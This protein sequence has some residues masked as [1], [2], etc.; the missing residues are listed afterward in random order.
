MTRV[1]VA[2]AVLAIFGCGGVGGDPGPGLQQAPLVLAAGMVPI[3]PAA[4]DDVS[5]GVDLARLGLG[6]P[7]VIYELTTPAN[8]P[9]VFDLLSRNEGNQGAVRV[10]VAHAR[11]GAGTPQGG[12]ETLA[13]VGVVPSG[14]GAGGTGEWYDAAGDGFAR[15][16]ISGAIDRDQILAVR[17]E[18]EAGDTTALVWIR[19]GP[20]SPINTAFT[21]GRNYAGVLEERTIY[22][23][24]SY[25]F[26]LPAIAV[27]GDRTTVVA[28]DGDQADPFRFERYEMRLQVDHDTGDVTGGAS[29]EPSPDTGYWRDHEIAALF[30]VLAVVTAGTDEVTLKL[31]FDRG[32][33]FAQTEEFVAGSSLYSARLVQI[34]MAADYTLGLVFWRPDVEGTSELIFVEGRP[35]AFDGGGSPTGFVFDAPRTLVRAASDIMPVIMGMDYSDGGDLVIG[36]GWSRVAW[37]PETRVSTIRTEFHA[38]VRMFG[39]TGFFDSLVEEDVTIARDPSV[40]LIRGATD[41]DDRDRLRIFYAYEGRNGVRH[42]TSDDGGRSWSPPV[43]VG[44]R[45]SY[46]PMIFAR[47]GDGRD[48]RVDILYLTWGEFGTELHLRHFEAYQRLAPQTFRLTESRMVEGD[49][50]VGGGG[51][52]GT[53]RPPRIAQAGGAFPPGGFKVTQISWFGYDATRDG[54]DIVVVFNEQT[55]SPY[56]VIFA[57]GD[58]GAV[59]AAGSA[60]LPTA[61]DGFVPAE[62]PPLAPGLTEP[63]R[64]PNPDHSNQLRVIRLE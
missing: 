31:S 53:D 33:T 58:F 22:S 26:G 20:V 19:V 54:D 55:T 28:Y 39:E 35:A 4:T 50:D 11:D 43:D 59:G 29:V 18:N 10:S 57:L 45:M 8:Q 14:T 7:G 41:G 63:V 2:V 30:N 64:P 13:G 62:P 15:V 46:Q 32:A 27:S 51:G 1:V 40:S 24:D 38:L 12:I 3:E 9:F 60:A 44:D 21:V 25:L 6:T 48:T 34:A 5:E 23:S 61:E 37:N 36:Y 17:A 49:R 47:G 52:D 56:D 16:S 42:R